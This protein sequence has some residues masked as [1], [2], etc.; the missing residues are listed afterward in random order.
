[1]KPFSVRCW[2]YL[3]SSQRKAAPIAAQGTLY[4]R[5]C[6]SAYCV[7]T[8]SY[9]FIWSMYYKLQIEKNVHF[10]EWFITSAV[11]VHGSW[12]HLA[13]E[14]KIAFSLNTGVTYN[15]VLIFYILFCY[16]IHTT[17][18]FVATLRIL[19]FHYCKTICRWEDYVNF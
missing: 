14:G 18:H 5:S 9:S 1:M 3:R 10:A 2:R 13:D 8:F 6:Y 16:N 17:M 15:L 7:K 11:I 4:S 12:P 19:F